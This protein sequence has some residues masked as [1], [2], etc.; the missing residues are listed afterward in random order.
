MVVAADFMIDKS[1]IF[2][3]DIPYMGKTRNGKSSGPG[4]QKREAVIG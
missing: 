4:D 2:A 3:Y 1:C